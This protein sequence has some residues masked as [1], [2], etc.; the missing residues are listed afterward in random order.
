M[1]SSSNLTSAAG[2]SITSGAWQNEELGVHLSAEPAPIADLITEFEQ[3]WADAHE[4]FERTVGLTLDETT[5]ATVRVA[6]MRPPVVGE[7]ASV[8]MPARTVGQVTSVS[9]YNPTV[10]AE[11]G[12]T[13]AIL[14]LRGGERGVAARCLTSGLCSPIPPRP[15]PS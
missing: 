1:V 2:Y 11:Q 10:P 13:D 7:F 4:L 6:C 5:S 14:G 8:G 15:T 12:D 3:I 9:S